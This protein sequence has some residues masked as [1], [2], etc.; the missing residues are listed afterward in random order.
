MK[1]I[2]E[3]IQT[4]IKDFVEVI[5]IPRTIRNTFKPKLLLILSQNLGNIPEDSKINYIEISDTD[6][7]L[8][9]DSVFL[10]YLPSKITKALCLVVKQNPSCYEVFVNQNKIIEYCWD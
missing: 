5:K 7:M 2:K 4:T 1:Q 6:G 3:I 9:L 8:Y 10:I